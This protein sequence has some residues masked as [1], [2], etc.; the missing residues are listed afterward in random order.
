MARQPEFLAGRVGT[1]TEVV[2]GDCLD[3]ASLEGALR[4]VHTAYYLVHSLGTRESFE[5]Q[6]RTAARNF[7][8]AARHAGVQRVVFREIAAAALAWHRVGD[9]AVSPPGIPQLGTV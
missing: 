8:A 1:G 3:P 7:A 6:D 2:R 5:E 4:G 9:V